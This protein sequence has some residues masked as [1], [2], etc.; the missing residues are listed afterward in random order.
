MWFPTSLCR[1]V[2][3]M[4]NKTNLCN[5]VLY[6]SVQL[7]TK[8]TSDLWQKKYIQMWKSRSMGYPNSHII[9]WTITM[10]DKVFSHPIWIDVQTNCIEVCYIEASPQNLQFVVIL[11]HSIIALHSPHLHLSSIRKHQHNCPDKSG[12]INHKPR[13]ETLNCK[14]P[15]K[16]PQ[17]LWPRKLKPRMELHGW[18]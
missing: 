7:C 14:P 10:T 2:Y 6:L 16:Q 8:E 5:L 3:G 13:T 9:N 11:W 15:P 4:Q 1:R 18:L 12:T 17:D